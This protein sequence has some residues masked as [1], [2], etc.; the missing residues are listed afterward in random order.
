VRWRSRGIGEEV[1]VVGYEVIARSEEEVDDWSCD[2]WDI[3][4][5]VGQLGEWENSDKCTWEIK[6]WAL[7]F[8]RDT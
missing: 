7:E 6:E 1:V 3:E 4:E 5:I 2:C 8:V